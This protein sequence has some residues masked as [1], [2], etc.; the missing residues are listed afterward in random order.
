MIN[1]L[2]KEKKEKQFSLFYVK[3]WKNYRNILEKFFIKKEIINFE[4][5]FYKW[6]YWNNKIL[7]VEINVH[8][9]GS[10]ID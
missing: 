2:I 9:D 4:K 6:I 8:F 3:N 7:F 1:Y 5:Q 10:G